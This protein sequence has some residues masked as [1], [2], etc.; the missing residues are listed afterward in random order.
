M[1]YTSELPSLLVHGLKACSSAKNVF[2]TYKSETLMCSKNVKVFN[3]KVPPVQTWTV[4]LI[5]MNQIP[6][7]LEFIKTYFKKKKSS[8]LNHSILRILPS[9]KTDKA[10]IN[11]HQCKRL[12][13]FS[14]SPGLSTQLIL[15]SA[16]TYVWKWNLVWV[17]LNSK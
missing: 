13:R 6:S 11:S 1:R 15:P 17:K 12:T 3:R 10:V 8:T 7:D 14:W 2:R 9:L 16:V 5:K 4:G